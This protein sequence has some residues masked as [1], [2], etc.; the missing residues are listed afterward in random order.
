LVIRFFALREP[1]NI[2]GSIKSMLDRCIEGGQAA[3]AAQISTLKSVFRTRL[4]LASKIFGSNVFRYLDAKGVWQTSVGL[5][6]GVMV[7]LDTLWE[8]HAR[9]FEKKG[10]VVNTVEA[11]LSKQSAFRVIIG[12]PNT[13]KAVKKRIDL[14]VKAIAAASVK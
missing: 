8:G 5:Y 11:L 12:R 10:H 2:K 3:N 7:A 1:A 6:D 13:A 9:I 14:L 4:D